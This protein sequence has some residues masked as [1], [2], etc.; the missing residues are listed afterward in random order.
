MLFFF[1]HMVS[2]IKLTYCHTINLAGNT[3]WLRFRELWLLLLRY[4]WPGSRA[5]TSHTHTAMPN[6]GLCSTDQAHAALHDIITSILIMKTETGCVQAS[7]FF[8][9]HHSADRVSC[10]QINILIASSKSPSLALLKGCFDLKLQ[11][12]CYLATTNLQIQAVKNV[13]SKGRCIHFMCHLMSFRHAEN[14]NVRWL[15][16]CDIFLGRMTCSHRFV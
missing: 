11:E 14:D 5:Q 8:F 6:C 15:L 1:L 7:K 13:I 3:F 4:N 16:S 10:W 2:F 9:K 12:K